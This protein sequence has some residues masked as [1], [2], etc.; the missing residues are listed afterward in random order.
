MGQDW[1]ELNE[2][3]V[4]ELKKL[5]KPAFNLDDLKTTAG[6]LKYTREIKRLLAEQME[7]PSDELVRFFASK[8][9]DAPLTAS[10]R[11]YFSGITKRS[12]N[13]LIN[14]RINERLKSA[15]SGANDFEAT[16]AKVYPNVKTKNQQV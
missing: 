16:P 2:A 4:A 5:T 12:F 13:Q 7:S 3:I 8:V 15:M 6:E 11:E 9:I 1:L 10:R 14:E